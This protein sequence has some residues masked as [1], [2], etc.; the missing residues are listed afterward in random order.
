MVIMVIMVMMEMMMEKGMTRAFDVLIL[1]H[2]IQVYIYIQ[3]P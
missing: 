1:I 3:R 2:L